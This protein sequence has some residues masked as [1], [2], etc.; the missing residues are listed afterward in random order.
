MPDV[1]TLKI[2]GRGGTSG[3]CPVRR[4]ALPEGWVV[5]SAACGRASF[6][7]NASSGWVPAPPCRKP[8]SGSVASAL[9]KR[10]EPGS[11]SASGS[12]E[13]SNAVACGS[14]RKVSKASMI[15]SSRGETVFSPVRGRRESLGRE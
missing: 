13:K 9:K 15:R 1:S 12:L 7:K 11:G 14:W 3:T 5:E 10:V 2:P 6:S 8:V 4:S